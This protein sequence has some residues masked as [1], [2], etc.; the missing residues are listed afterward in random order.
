MAIEFSCSQCGKLLRVGDDAVGKKAR[1]PSGGTVQAI[2]ASSQAFQ[3]PLQGAMAPTGSAPA[4]LNPYQA[5]AS[6]PWNPPHET[7]FGQVTPGPIQPSL[8][9]A[10]DVISRT[11]AIFTSDFWTMALVGFLFWVCQAVFVFVI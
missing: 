6:G 5:P 8:I 1:C 7:A 9:D 11:W 4:E 2:P 10:G 3:P